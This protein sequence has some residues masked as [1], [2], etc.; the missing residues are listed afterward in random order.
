MARLGPRLFLAVVAMLATLPLAGAGEQVLMW[1]EKTGGGLTTLAY[2]PLDPAQNPL[3]ML[4]C[5]SGMNIVVLDVHKE[6]PDAKPGDPLTIE[7]SSAKAQS[8]VDGE[9]G[10]NETT[11][12]T[13]GEASDI[14]VKPVLEVLRDSGPLTI[15]MGEASATMSEVG[16]AES[17]G[18]FVENCKL[19]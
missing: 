8:P 9:V 14:N 6:I 7:L 11:G 10:K 13:F 19:E 12:K 15:K 2:G 17:V 16:R 4:S 3:F 1:T 5:F 18:K